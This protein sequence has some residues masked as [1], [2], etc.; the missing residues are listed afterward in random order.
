M[1]HAIEARR[2]AFKALHQ[3]GCFIIPNPWDIGSA[4]L[5]QHMGFKAL[6]STSSGHAWS[7]GQQDGRVPLAQVLDHLRQLVQ[8]VDLPINADFV[9]GYA[10][11][12]KG[13]E[14]HVHQAVDT[15]IAGLSI[16][17]ATGDP[18]HPLREQSDAVERIQA[19]RQAIDHAGGTV[20]LVGR[21]ENFLAGQPDLDGTVQR[22]QAYAEAGA[23]CLYAPGIHSEEHIRIL[24]QAVAPKPLNVLIGSNHTLTLAD[25]AGLGV[26]RISVGGALARCAWGA[27]HKAATALAQGHFKGF[28]EALPYPQINGLF[29]PGRH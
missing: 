3:Q 11:T 25:L 24:V 1:T 26:R 16:E 18:A 6:A 22:L 9:A 4:V 2:A 14:T 12:P 13:V 17:D 8:A 29:G 19:A 20:L 23:D 28:D 10:D 7:V 27:L 5:L 15:G 21:A